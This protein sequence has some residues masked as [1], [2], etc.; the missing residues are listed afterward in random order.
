MA[1]FNEIADQ[2]RDL[3]DRLQQDPAQLIS[4]ESVKFATDTVQKLQQRTVEQQKYISL[5]GEE[6][7]ISRRITLERERVLATTDEARASITSGIEVNQKMLE[8]IQEASEEYAAATGHVK[9]LSKEEI[10]L[11][12]L[13]IAKTKILQG[14]TDLTKEQTTQVLDQIELQKK[15]LTQISEGNKLRNREATLTQIQEQYLGF[16]AD[17]IKKKMDDARMTLNTTAGRLAVIGAALKHAF[18]VATDQLRELRDTGLSINQTFEAGGQIIR[19]SFAGGFLQMGATVKAIGALRAEFGDLTFQTDATVRNASNLHTFF[20]LSADEAGRLVEDL[21]KQAGMSAEAQDNFFRSAKAF[22]EINRLNPG[23]LLDAVA[24]NAKIFAQYGEQGAAAFF[25][26]AAAAERIGVSLEEIDQL[27]NTLVDIDT[28]F[29][30]VSRLRGLGINV[31]DPMQL[32]QV[33]QYGTQEDIA[34][35]MQKQLGDVDIANLGRIQRNLLA[36]TFGLDLA[37]LERFQTG[38]GGAGTEGAAVRE[39]LAN[40]TDQQVES[41]GNFDKGMQGSLAVLDGFTR[42]I[43]FTTIA[44]YAMAAAAAVNSLKG[45]LGIGKFLGMSLGRG[46]AAGAAAAAGGAG[47]AAGGIGGMFAKMFGR[48]GTAAAGGAGGA[49]LLGTAGSALGTGA[50]V[51]TAGAVGLAIGELINKLTGTA[52]LSDMMKRKD[53]IKAAEASGAQSEVRLAALRQITAPIHAAQRAREE[54]MTRAQADQI[55]DGIERG[56]E[57][58]LEVDSRKLTNAQAKGQGHTIGTR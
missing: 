33:A 42:G 49:G 28:M 43:H 18:G 29:Q 39:N 30:N 52:S 47:S 10:A 56:H 27:G 26:S 54:G 34:A 57:V 8:L 21:T 4:E 6:E 50:A 38:G 16:S 40:A 9:E 20:R 35:E 46:G 37:T 2:F 14:Q 22:A 36:Q 17:S 51:A 5:L 3:V 15:V 12:E 58:V 44:L 19:R 25:R 1:D 7:L 13:E 45:G 53:E 31:A 23:R 55:I 48:G 41:L 24:K 32:A 11:I